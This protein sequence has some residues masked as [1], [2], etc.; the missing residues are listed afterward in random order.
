MLATGEGRNLKG[1]A[2]A[3]AL[4]AQFGAGG[5]DYAG[6]SCADLPVWLEARH[7]IMV[8]GPDLERVARQVAEAERIFAPEES[9]LQ[10][11]LRALRLHQWAWDLLIFLPLLAAHRLA[12]PGVIAG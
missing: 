2:K 10:A 11:L 5:F 1:A 7:A 12:G 3:A 9:R 4:V 6:D 8:G